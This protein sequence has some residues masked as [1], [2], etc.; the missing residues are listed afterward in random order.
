MRPLGSLGPVLLLR[1]LTVD[2]RRPD[3]EALAAE[4]R[5]ERFL[6]RVLPHAARS[7]AASIVVLPREQARAAAVAYLYCRMLDT[8]E[9]L[10]GDP[11]ARAAGLQRFAAR[12]DRDPMP[13]PEP[14][15]GSLARDDRDRVHQ[16]LIARCALVDDVFATLDGPVRERIGRLVSAMAAEM[17]WASEAFERQRGVLAG[18]EQLS[19]YCR[20]VI[21]HPAVFVIELINDGDCPAPVRADAFEASE[22]I[23]LANVTRDIEADLARGIAYHP[24]LAPYLGALP[25]SPA[26]EAAVR[27]ARE[28]FMRLALGRAGAYR[29]LFERLDLGG[30]AKIRTA[31]VLM[32]LFTDLHYRGCAARTGHRP[33]PG[34]GG[35]LAVLAGALGALL[36]PRWASRTVTRVERDFLAAAGGL[37]SLPPAAVGSQVI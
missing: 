16:L 5:P 10:I 32:L 24:S 34:P 22:M 18:E 21:G 37:R 2:R 11:G 35:R 25:S 1:G 19:R 9:D 14:I 7:F 15:A 20:G 28:D 12:F 31:A 23:Q 13:A 30:T 26:A 27:A 29:R 3:L 36:S 6:W 33:W 17:T 8:Y 4:R